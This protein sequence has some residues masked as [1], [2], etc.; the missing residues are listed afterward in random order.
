MRTTNQRKPNMGIT[1]E[2]ADE[3]LAARASCQ[4]RATDLMVGYQRRLLRQVQSYYSAALV[5]K[6]HLVD[7]VLRESTNTITLK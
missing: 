2:V 6:N 7:L 4:Q 1:G 3:S 5:P